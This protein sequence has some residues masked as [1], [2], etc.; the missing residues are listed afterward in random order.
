M[1]RVRRY[2]IRGRRHM[3]IQEKVYVT[4]LGLRNAVL[5]RGTEDIGALLENAV[6]QE[7]LRR[8]WSVSV[9][10][11]GDWEIDFVAEREGRREYFQVTYL[12][13]TPETVEREFRSLLAIDDN[14]PKTVLSMDEMD[15]GRDGIRHVNVARWLL[16]D[17]RAGLRAP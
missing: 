16:E 17:D 8:G 4:K 1:S 7:L 13:A 6:Q 15:L 3:E 9:G 12:L 2:D 5:R 10:K 14:F 11:V